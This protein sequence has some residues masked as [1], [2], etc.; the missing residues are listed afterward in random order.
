[1]EPAFLWMGHKAASAAIAPTAIYT[2]VR[3]DRRNRDLCVELKKSIEKMLNVD[4]MAADDPLNHSDRVY[5][6]PP[7]IAY[8]QWCLEN[9]LYLDPVNDLGPHPFVGGDFIALPSHVVPVDA[10]DALESFFNQMI[11]E[12]VSARWLL[13]EGVTAEAPHFS[14]SDVSLQLTEPRPSLS[15]ATE[16]VKS[17]FRTSYSL[18]DKIAFFVN[19]YMSLQIPDKLVS[20]RRVWQDEKKLL[21]KQFDTKDNWAFCALHWVAKDF[22]EDEY[23]E[24]AEPEARGLSDIRN[25]LEHR[26]LRVTAEAPPNLPPQGDLAL[27]VSREQF[28][29]KALHLLK[30]ARSALIYLAIGVQFEEKRREPSYSNVPIEELP[31]RPPLRDTEKL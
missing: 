13:Y 14:D 26:Y 21:R 16:K 11:Q 30:L 27:M 28:K 7:E 19:A 17:A 5:S 1:M 2:D 8:R 4:A 29:A 6:S 18:F 20:F 3:R 23:D 9:F 31:H 25:H 15:L 12:Y 10:R 22:F 24:V